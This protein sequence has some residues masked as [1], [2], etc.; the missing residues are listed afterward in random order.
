M[1]KKFYS[2]VSLVYVP[3][4]SVIFLG[5]RDT[6]AIVSDQTAPVLFLS[7]T[8]GHRIVP[9]LLLET[10]SFCMT[11]ALFYVR[12][13]FISRELDGRHY[14]HII[15]TTSHFT[16]TNTGTFSTAMPTIWITSLDDGT[17]LT[18]Q[19]F[20]Y[21]LA[22]CQFFCPKPWS[23]PSHAMSSLPPLYYLYIRHKCLVLNIPKYSV[24]LSTVILA[25]GG[26][27]SW[28]KPTFIKPHHHRSNNS[29]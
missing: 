20:Y 19:K 14:N 12:R 24:S 9:W 3:S 8:I 15:T 27:E 29:S 7:D 16:T 4:F 26:F 28:K 23:I 10:P 5:F 6:S 11:S 21:C 13:T 2:D 18:T 1:I 25:F 17:K 22:R